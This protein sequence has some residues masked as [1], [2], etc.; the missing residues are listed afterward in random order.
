MRTTIYCTLLVSA[1]AYAQAP[2]SGP[3]EAYTF[4]APT[5]SFRA[6]I[7]YIGSSSLGP[8][9]L[10][11]VN[12][13]SVA[14]RRNYAL[15]VREDKV[16]VVS[17]LGTDAMNTS[18]LSGIFG[19]PE[20]TAWSEDASLAILFSKTDG[21]I[22]FVKGL[23]SAPE[24]SSPI[25]IS[26]LGGALTFV[27]VN[28]R[29]DRSAIGID[30]ETGGV[31]EIIG[32]NIVPLATIAKSVAGAF[33]ANSASFYV[34]DANRQVTAVNWQDRTTQTWGLDIQDPSA[35]RVIRDRDADTL[36]VTGRTDRRLSSYEASTGTPFA[37]IELD[38]EPTS[39]EPL[40]RTS[41]SLATRT[42]KTDPL[43]SYVNSPQPAVYFVPA[44]PLGSGIGGQQ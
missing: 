22:Q 34:L 14:P 33:A 41:Y 42:G 26:S 32:Q 19:K 25:S 13:G 29:G 40:G 43:W 8:A 38:F 12:Y 20:G 21:W 5:S 39:I 15:A 16:V 17:G 36:F 31:F 18:E 24:A 27:S 28:A 9:L 4:D 23:P 3:V 44:T 30:G 2:L 11:R 35:L 7:G 6:L 37:T 1:A 10:D